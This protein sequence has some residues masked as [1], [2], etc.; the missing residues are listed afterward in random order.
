MTRNELPKILCEIL[1]GFGGRAKMMDVFKEF[2]RLYGNKM[3]PSEDIFYTW[4]YD[5]RWAATKLRKNGIM[6]QAKEQENTYGQDISSKGIWE[7]V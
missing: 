5:I 7:L 1:K 2:W 6:R 4:N 3:S